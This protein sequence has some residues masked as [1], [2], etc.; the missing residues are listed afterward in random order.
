MQKIYF[1]IIL[2]FFLGITNAQTTIIPDPL[3]EFAL[4]ELGI[5]KDG[6]LNHRVATSDISNILSLNIYNKDIRDLAGI[7][8]FINLAELNCGSNKLTNLDISKN[9][10]LTRLDCKSN[11]LTSLDI[12]KNIN[13]IRLNCE[14]NQITSIDLSQNSKLQYL[15][16]FKNQLK[17][18]NLKNKN[19][20]LLK[21]VYS[22][23]N[24]FLTCIGVDNSLLA[25]G[26]I[27]PYNYWKKDSEAIYS[28]NCQSFNNK[29]DEK[30]NTSIRIHPNP[31]ANKLSVESKQPITKVEIY[32]ILGGRVMVEYSNFKNIRVDDLSRGVYLIRVYSKNGYTVRNLI[33]K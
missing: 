2:L 28:E 23:Q 13:L 19:N 30:L 25:N 10:A 1:S 33:K 9:I 17:Y 7:E 12:S 14:I 3:F 15:Y 26:K 4:I 11:Q 32:S 18:L 22:Y 16:C 20:S 24:P 8:D 6:E 31:V 21:K 29:D 27:S 5:D